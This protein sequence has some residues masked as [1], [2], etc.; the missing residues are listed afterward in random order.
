ML[1]L[2]GYIIQSLH[3]STKI[4]YKRKLAKNIGKPVILHIGRYIHNWFNRFEM[5]K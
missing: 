5:C 2:A 1:R 3:E 4:A